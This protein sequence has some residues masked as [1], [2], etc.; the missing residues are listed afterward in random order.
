MLLVFSYSY[1]VE[2]HKQKY[3]GGT[4]KEIFDTKYSRI[5]PENDWKDKELK[6]KVKTMTETTYNYGYSGKDN[7]VKKT[8]TKFRAARIAAEKAH[9]VGS[10]ALRMG[11]RLFFTQAACLNTLLVNLFPALWVVRAG[12]RAISF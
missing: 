5:M 7:E 1:S 10:H 4:I 12:K 11:N 6:G 2:V 8:V 9:V 3:L